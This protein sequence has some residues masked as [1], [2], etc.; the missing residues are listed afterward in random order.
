LAD[1]AVALARRTHIE[2]LLGSYPA[3][4][5]D[6]LALLQR[7]FRSQAS[8]LDVATVACNEA[9]A[10]GYRQFRRDH[11][12]RFTLGDVAKGLAGAAVL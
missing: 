10:P 8:A 9:I 11:I 6:E 3:I 1:S 4:T 12:D 5:P 7:W 2:S